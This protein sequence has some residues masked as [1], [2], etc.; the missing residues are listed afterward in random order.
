MPADSVTRVE[1]PWLNPN[2]DTVFL[3]EWIAKD[4]QKVN[5]GDVLCTIETSKATVDIE[6]PVSGYLQSSV[7]AQREVTVGDLLAIIAGSLDPLTE[8]IAPYQ[9][10]TSAQE[11]Q[12]TQRAL[13]LI[14]EHGLEKAKFRHLPLVRER[15][16]ADFLEKQKPVSSIAHR[17]SPIQLRAAKMLS[18]SKQTIP[19]SYLTKFL[20]AAPVSALVA[21]MALDLDAMIS[22]SD[23]FSFC[24]AREL[25][26][27]PKAC[28]SWTDQGLVFHPGVNLCVAINLADG[29]LVAPAVKDADSLEL[30]SLVAALRGLQMRALRG[31]LKLEDLSGG[32]CMVTSL[33]GSGI[34]QVIPILYPGHSIIFGIADEWLVGGEGFYALTAS[35]DHRVLNGA[36]SGEILCAIAERM[37]GSHG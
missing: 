8:V 9:L 37:L 5:Q 7:P 20:P 3:I 36:E 18:R 29:T 1:V 26:D 16:V 13:A 17:H 6:A 30:I 21:R 34:N 35:F 19:H 4:G 11:P 15:D 23:W 12:F 22:I 28:A 33:I 25:R 10:E 24:V 31:Q 14:T 32:N 2:D 27:R